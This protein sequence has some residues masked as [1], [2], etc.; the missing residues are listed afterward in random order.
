M[1]DPADKPAPSDQ[2]P[3]NMDL[4]KSAQPPRIVRKRK[5][6]FWLVWLIPLV[7][8]LIGLSIV[9]HDWSNRGPTIS[10]R[11]DSASG[12]EAGKTQ[13]KFR[14]VV[15]G[16][17]TNI[18]L[19]DTGD[20][21]LV[22]AE[23]NLDA[24]GLAK[25]GTQFWVVRPTIGLSGVSGLSTLLSGVYINADTKTFKS[26]APEKLNFV[27]LT[28]PPAISSDRPG[29]RFKLRSETLGSLG[30]GAPIYFLRI[31]VGVVTKYELEENGSFVDIEVFVDAPYD[32]YVGGNTRFWNESGVYVN[33]GSDGLTVSTESLVSVLA[34]GLAFGNFGP[35]IPLATNQTFK[36]Y[37]NKALADEVPIGLAVPV[38]MKFYQSTKG[39]EAQAPV[40]FQGVEI[41]I[42]NSADLDFDIY[43]GEFFTHVKATLYPA[44]LGSVFQTMQRAN[45][46]VEQATES[47]AM[48]VK[49]GLRAEL[50]TASLLTGSLYVSMSLVRD[51]PP[52]KEVAATVPL[53]MPTVVTSDLEDIQKQIA[54]IVDNINKIPFEQLSADLSDS[55]KEL[56]ELGK[57]LNNTLAP[58]LSAVLKD[59]QSTLG[60]VDEFLGAS[61]ELPARLDSSLKEIDK[62][63]RATKSLID[64]LRAQPNSIIFG[65][66]SPS[67]S[68]DNLGGT[69]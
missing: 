57:S 44:R 46:T 45:R 12:L 50:K 60:Q 20:E 55:L 39:L 51:A 21:V 16:T 69:P 32:K 27:A 15:V 5:G 40:T 31:P 38:T 68:R 8:S 64:E 42:V 48:M 30:P 18:R 33:V 54:S 10:I 52:V 63:V 43:K 13:I 7:A 35:P 61:D 62:A 53:E 36:L 56:T 4:A 49:R 28:E 17:V 41:G 25:E 59:L 9:W 11:L 58:E 29:S 14:D 65:E 6:N 67:Y 3:A 19:S 2:Q 26:N 47:L 37:G 24:K 1:V 66:P 34:G 23:L 22:D